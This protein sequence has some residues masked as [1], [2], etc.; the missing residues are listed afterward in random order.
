VHL[1]RDPP[2]YAA[3]MQAFAKLG[4]IKTA[5]DVWD[6]LHDRLDRE[7]QEVGIVLLLDV[8]LN[9]RGAAEVSRG[10]RDSTVVPI[11]DILRLALL[12]G[13]NAIV[14]C[15][16]HPTGLSAP[17]DDD[18]SS[19]LALARACDEV[20]L[21]L[22]DHVILGRGEYYSMADAGVL[23]SEPVIPEEPQAQPTPVAPMPAPPESTQV[24][25]DEPMFVDNPRASDK[26]RWDA[27]HA[28]YIP[29][30][31]AARQMQ[32]D[33][34]RKYGDNNWRTWSS[35]GDRN[36]LE[37]LEA[38][39]DKIGDKIIELGATHGFL[40]RVKAGQHEVTIDTEGYTKDQVDRV[41]ATAKGRGLHASYDGRYVLVRDLSGV[42]SA[43][44]NPL[45]VGRSLFTDYL[46]LHHYSGSLQITDL[47]NA[48]KRGKKVAQL[49][50]LPKTHHDSKA[51]EI[52]SPLADAIVAANMT[53]PQAVAFLE[54]Q[55]KGVYRLDEQDLRG[56]DVEPPST[57]I[58]LQNRLPDGAMLN[59]SASPYDF[60]IRSSV[61]LGGRAAPGMMQDTLYYPA[62][63]KAQA[64]QSA[65]RFY[66]W[67][68][69]HVSEAAKLGMQELR[70]VWDSIGVKYDYH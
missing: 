41:I 31:E 18:K 5:K 68:R 58:D 43:R 34:R 62:G 56:I 37:K 7:D 38:R 49:T 69:G 70:Q 52:I 39:A 59:I 45:D 50:L 21:M 1:E 8:G 67:L 60:H 57:T 22:M 17:S 40:D 15:H 65:E 28:A 10:E 44:A 11:P 55:G 19:T 64:K 46:K 47:T 14:F 23:K 63:S 6:V 33:L 27:L 13:A 12:D 54:S 16:N 3:C 30:I 2:E 9:V 48:G 29:A 35:K 42:G 4:Q 26:E 51:A 61:P 53:Y 24:E 20:G 25:P 36:K 32:I 66:E